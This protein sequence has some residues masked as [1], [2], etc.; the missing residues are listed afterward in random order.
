MIRFSVVVESGGY[1]LGMVC[2]LLI[3]VASL[4]AEH[5]LQSTRTSVVVALG[6]SSHGSRALEHRLRGCS[7]WAELLLEMWDLPRSGAETVSSALADVLFTAEPPGKP[8]IV[9]FFLSFRLLINQCKLQHNTLTWFC[10][11]RGQVFPG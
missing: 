8:L 7:T 2:G 10:A 3:E 1:S 5:G 6:F 11:F 4:V 9:F